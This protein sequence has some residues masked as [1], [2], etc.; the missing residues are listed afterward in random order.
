MNYWLNLLSINVSII[1]GKK[2]KKGAGIK[3][4]MAEIIRNF[5]M[6]K[7]LIIIYTDGLRTKRSKAT[8]SA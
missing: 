2:V 7:E 8:S 4:T 3:Q 1:V 5:D 6:E